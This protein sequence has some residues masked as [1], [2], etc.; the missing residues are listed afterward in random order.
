M[1]K[2]TQALEKAARERLQRGQDE[3]TVSTTSP[4]VV[5][6]ATRRGVGEV[7]PA[8]QVEI[9]PHIVS[10]AAPK[11]AIA[12]QYRILRTN[13]LSLRMRSGSKMILLTS[14]VPGE[15]KSVTAVN[16]AL[17]LARQENLRVVLI[18]ADMRKSS[19]PRWLG[20]KDRR[21]GLSTVLERGGELDGSLV[22][23]ESPRLTVLPAGPVPDHPAELLES[24]AMKRVLATLKNQ[25][26]LVIVDAPPVLP[27]ADPS[28]LAAQ[29]DGVLLVVRAGKTQR[30]TVLAAQE[31]LKK[32]KA[33]IIGGVLTHVEYYL[34]G[35]R[36]YYH[37]YR[38]AAE[39]PDHAG[40]GHGLPPVAYGRHERAAQAGNGAA[41]E[42]PEASGTPDAGMAA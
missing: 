1:S 19:I 33:N 13:F 6:L 31:L 14:A 15:G 38:Q 34:P 4:V 18:D 29:A 37:Y 22:S 9:D 32:A 3:P 39:A 8:G 16:L 25:F 26:D 42:A 10:A 27:V 40:G 5:S 12:E 30:K 28:I 23:L 35:Y 21:A 2:I 41:A 17:S 20:L 24:I 7:T 11:S 36:R